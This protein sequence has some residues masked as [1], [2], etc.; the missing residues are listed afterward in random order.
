MKVV[1]AQLSDMHFKDDKKNLLF[2]R[3]DKIVSAIVASANNVEICLILIT[4]DISY[5]GTMEEYQVAQGFFEELNS[6]LADS[7]GNVEVK[8]IFI[9]GNHDCMLTPPN[10]VRELILPSISSKIADIPSD[11]VNTLIDVQQNYFNFAKKWNQDSI[12]QLTDGIFKSI[13]IKT[14]SGEIG[15]NLI[16]SAW[17]STLHENPGGLLFP[18]DEVRPVASD[19]DNPSPLAIT[20][21]HHPYQWFNPDN[22]KLLKNAVEAMSDIIFTGHEHDSDNYT[23]THKKQNI[24]YVEGGVLQG[25]WRNFCEFNIVHVDLENKEYSINVY[26][27]KDEDQYF[28]ISNSEKLKFIRNTHRLRNEYTVSDDFDKILSD[29]GVKFSHPNKD[30]LNLED[31]FVYPQ[32]RQLHL[33]GDP[34]WIKTI[35]QGHLSEFLLKN[36][37]ILFIGGDKSGKS[38]L[39]KIIFRDLRKSE[40]IPLI[41]SGDNFR[42]FDSTHVASIIKKTLESTYSTPKFEKYHQLN[43]DKKVLIVDDYHKCP[44]NAKSKDQLIKELDQHFGK[45]ILFGDDQL[46]FTDLISE[47]TGYRSSFLDYSTCEIMEFGKVKR[48]DLL[49]KWYL[50]GNIYAAEE[51]FLK[52]EAIRAEK[53]ISSLIGNNFVPSFPLFILAMLQQLEIRNPVETTSGSY[54]YLYETL[55]TMS[56][57]KNPYKDVD[58]DTQYSYLSE[59][60]YALFLKKL[61][62]I[63]YGQMEEWHTEYCNAYKLTINQ[64]DILDYLN[65]VAILLV[66]SGGISFR[67]PYMYFYFV[68]RYFRDHITE[69]EIR[70][71]I[72]RMCGRLHHTESANIIIFLCYLSKDP[73]I[74]T[75]LLETSRRLFALYPECDLLVDTKSIS[76]LIPD[77]PRV[78][79]EDGDVDENHRI[80]LEEEDSLADNMDNDGK[81]LTDDGMTDEDLQE[82]LQIN[83]AFK[84]IQILGQLLRNFPGSLKGDQKF[85]LAQECY[86]LGLRVLSFVIKN[87]QSSQQDLVENVGVILQS[88]HPKWP[89]ERLNEEVKY[90]MFSVLEG[91][92]FVVIRHTSDSVG[93]ER[94]SLTYKDILKSSKNVSYRFIDLSVQLENFKSFP[95]N[96]VLDLYK[97]VYKNGF[98]A[99]LL[100]H[101]VWYYFYIYPSKHDLMESVCKKLGIQINPVLKP[102]SPKMLKG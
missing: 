79:L 45:I 57:S 67:Y 76:R 50:L 77:V 2:E 80:I 81:E 88:K 73:F 29:P 85:A 92:A 28:E 59:L 51:A 91:L 13:K 33:P 94:L 35:L 36:N 1:F 55:L 61:R 39:A 48:R 97:N 95:K 40:L 37:K 25:D 34:E 66:D 83:V 30:A 8:F 31:I 98:S 3:I 70:Q 49:E 53:I 18:E 6:K 14:P 69:A 101:L 24:E 96:D 68:A 27:W 46:R 10:N 78:L 54:G 82:I 4:G 38:S 9:P 26:S 62:S 12:I 58:I 90:L 52:K 22:A 60:A 84:T 102:Q 74:L 32:I 41:I 19:I 63:D 64:V 44:L 7:L 17:M 11:I 5:S 42:N 89:Y 15:I 75:N 86:S 23:K 72:Q 93:L 56:L 47:N 99:Q 100:R 87:I 65:E 21:M 16:N 20:L 43:N 71:H